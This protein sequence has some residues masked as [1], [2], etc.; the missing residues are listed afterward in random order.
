MKQDKC[1][2]DL[3]SLNTFVQDEFGVIKDILE[4]IQ[5]SLVGH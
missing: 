1:Q 4:A 3:T 2:S 5:Y